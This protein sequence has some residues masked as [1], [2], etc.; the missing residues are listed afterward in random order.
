MSPSPTGPAVKRALGRASNTYN[1]NVI[2][3]QGSM[4]IRNQDYSSLD[5]SAQR[6]IFGPWSILSMD[7]SAPGGM[8][9]NKGMEC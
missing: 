3:W 2:G 6:C 8:E 5:Y 4:T 1:W 9:W 7:Y